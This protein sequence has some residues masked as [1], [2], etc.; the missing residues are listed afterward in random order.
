MPASVSTGEECGNNMSG[1]GRWRNHQDACGILVVLVGGISP[2]TREVYI[3]CRSIVYSPIQSLGFIF[4][5]TV[6][7]LIRANCDVGSSD[8]DAGRFFF[9]YVYFVFR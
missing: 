1:V 5:R 9:L 2:Q 4:V 6:C 8:R 3:S 7:L